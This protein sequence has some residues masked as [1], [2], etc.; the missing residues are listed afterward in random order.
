[1]DHVVKPLASQLVW[2]VEMVHITTLFIVFSGKHTIA[3]QFALD[4]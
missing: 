4:A 1:M 2:K 3:K